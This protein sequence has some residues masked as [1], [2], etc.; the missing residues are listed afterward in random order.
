MWLLITGMAAQGADLTRVEVEPGRSSHGVVVGVVDVPV[1]VVLE[2]VVDCVGS[3]SWFPDVY[4]TTVVSDDGE[5]IRCAGHTDLPWPLADRSW[6][7]D[8]TVERG[9][10]GSFVVPFTLAEGNLEELHGR[11]VLEGLADG[12]TRV[13]YEAWVDLGFWVP[14]ALL[15]WATNRVLPAILEGIEAAPARPALVAR[16]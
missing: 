3:S 14:P 16:R 7:I 11:Y 5:V 10:D 6:R 15:D 12:R 8:T 1:A 4:G 13:T 2:R 9:A